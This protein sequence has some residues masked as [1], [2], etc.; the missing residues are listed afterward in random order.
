MTCEVILEGTHGLLS[1]DLGIYINYN[2]DQTN[3]QFTK[4][5]ALYI[6]VYG[7]AK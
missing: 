6:L 2:V 4:A 5:I 1:N 3:D 7:E